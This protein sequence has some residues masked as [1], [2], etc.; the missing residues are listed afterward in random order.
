MELCRSPHEVLQHPFCYRERQ[1]ML[2]NRI[3]CEFYHYQSGHRPWRHHWNHL[4]HP[5]PRA[6]QSAHRRDLNLTRCLRH[7]RS[8]SHGGHSSALRAL[9]FYCP[10]F[11]SS[12]YSYLI[13][14]HA[15]CPCLLRPVRLFLKKRS[16]PDENYISNMKMCKITS[17]PVDLV[18]CL[19]FSS[20]GGGPFSILTPILSRG[21]VLLSWA[22]VRK[23]H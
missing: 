5:Q 12:D 2:E 23:F 22:L 1:V 21:R 4:V 16:Y 19:A 17:K 20:S 3:W 10:K 9:M 8:K 14:L 18:T 13:K 11:N 15:L 6:G 7:C